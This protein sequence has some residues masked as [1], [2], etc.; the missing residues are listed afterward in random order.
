MNGNLQF[1]KNLPWFCL[2]LINDYTKIHLNSNLKV[3]LKFCFNLKRESLFF[4][5]C[6]FQPLNE[7]SPLRFLDDA[8]A[9]L[10]PVFVV[11]LY[12]C[13]CPNFNFFQYKSAQRCSAFLSIIAFPGILGLNSLFSLVF[14]SCD[15]FKYSRFLI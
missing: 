10:V 5:F 12:C 7:E 4:S 3:L 9:S 13:C 2:G 15:F 1:F 6:C 14:T 11:L 8:S